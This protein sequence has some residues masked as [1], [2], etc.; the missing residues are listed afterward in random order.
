MTFLISEDEALRNKI[1]GITVSDQKA[2]G[3]P[4]GVWFGQ[5]DQEIRTQE[6][7]YITIDMIDV[8]RDTEREMRGKVHPNYLPDISTMYDYA[9][10][11]PI[12]FNPTLHS[13]E[14]NMPIPVY[15][16]YQLTT[17]SRHPKH[18]REIMAQLI[19]YKLPLRFGYLEIVENSTTSGTTTTNTVTLRRLDVVSVSKRDVTEQAKRLFVNAIT[20][21]VSS[22]LPVSVYEALYKVSQLNLDTYAVNAGDNVS[23]VVIS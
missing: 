11:G 14:I 8:Q 4:V 19:G 10:G 3:R 6:Y 2:S 15:I 13:W 21:R 1:L 17:Y 23:H 16:D 12:T 20:V 18:D 5:P 7:P 22:E 9:T